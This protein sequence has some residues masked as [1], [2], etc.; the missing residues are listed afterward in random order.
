MALTKIDDRGLNT[1][2]ELLDDEEIR[3]GNSDDCK[4][5]HDSTT[6]HTF[7]EQ[8]SG[9]NALIIKA[10]H[11]RLKGHSHNETMLAANVNGNV[12]LYY[13]TVFI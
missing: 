13:N 8:T 11:P 5:Y 9:V 7:I 10:N 3:L 1:P 12:E 6:N 2:I 4:I